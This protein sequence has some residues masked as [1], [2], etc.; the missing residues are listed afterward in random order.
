MKHSL[1]LSFLIAFISTTLIAQ[2]PVGVWKTIDDNTGEAR[3][4]VEIYERNGKFYG[5]IAKTLRPD[6]DEFC[7]KCPGEKKNK[8]IIGLVIIEGL[9]PHRDYWRSGTILDPESGSEYSCTIWFEAAKT[10]E[11]KVRG[12]HWTGISRTQTWYRVP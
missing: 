1:F 7:E 11:L 2:S 6:A 4:Y 10:K 8:P 5:K 12:R 9:T 3:S